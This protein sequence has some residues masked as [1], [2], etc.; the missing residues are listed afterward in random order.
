ML[1]GGVTPNVF[2]T[3]FMRQGCPLSPLLFAIVTHPLFF[4]LANLAASGDIVG[5]Q[6]PYARQ[7]VAQALV[8]DTFMFLQASKENIERSMQVW[9]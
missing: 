3:R 2:P 9:E 7:L 6:L 4:M 5:L 8:D 1:N